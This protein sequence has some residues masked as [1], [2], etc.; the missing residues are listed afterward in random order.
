MVRSRD[1]HWSAFVALIGIG[2]LICGCAGKPPKRDFGRAYEH[3]QK[4]EFGAAIEEYEAFLEEFP[5]DARVHYNFGIAYYRQGQYDRAASENKEA[6]ALVPGLVPAQINLGL[7]YRRLGKRPEALESLHIAIAM[8]S[9]NARSYFNL[10]VIC[11]QENLLDEAIGYYERAVHF[12]PDYRQAYANLGVVYQEKGALDRAAEAFERAGDLIPESIFINL[13]AAFYDQGAVEQAIW[14]CGKALAIRPES[15]EARFNL[16]LIYSKRGD[17]AM[18]SASMSGCSGSIRSSNRPFWDWLWRILGWG[19]SR[20]VPLS[21]TRTRIW[22]SDWR[23]SIWRCPIIN[24]GAWIRLSGITNW[25]CRK[26]PIRWMPISYWGMPIW[27]AGRR[28]GR[29]AN[30]ER[31][32]NWIQR[33]WRRARPWRICWSKRGGF[34]RRCANGR[35]S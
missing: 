12:K 22:I 5:E 11:W 21:W 9:T 33:E 20:S 25:R 29:F 6:L 10:G 4:E 15:V 16:G 28:N 19:S 17:T 26:N 18:R 34:G 14:A 35:R 31:S 30:I 1:R 3:T 8:D 27:K 24:P 23:T 2:L 13:A 7:C 32:F